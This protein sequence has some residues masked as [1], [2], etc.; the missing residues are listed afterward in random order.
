MC[1]VRY[2]RRWLSLPLSSSHVYCDSHSAALVTIR[3]LADVQH[4]SG[5]LRPLYCSGIDG[6]PRGQWHEP[7]RHMM[8]ARQPD[9]F[10]MGRRFASALEVGEFA[11]DY[12]RPRCHTTLV[13]SNCA[14][15][16]S[17]GL[18]YTLPLLADSEAVDLT[19]AVLSRLNAAPSA[20]GPRIPWSTCRWKRGL[21]THYLQVLRSK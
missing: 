15:A 9:R 21:I 7:L 13:R 19:S 11:M 4:C 16:C 17:V 1:L 2:L 14:E 20:R 8:Y 6:G 5:D 10:P 12:A 3:S 18:P